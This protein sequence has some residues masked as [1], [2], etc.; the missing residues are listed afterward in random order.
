MTPPVFLAVDGGNSK[1]DVVI[2][3][4]DGRV[5]AAVRGPGS[6]PHALGLAGALDLLDGL[7]RRARDAADAAGPARVAR[8]ARAAVFLAGADL[9]VEVERLTAAV[10]GLGWADEST[11]DNDTFALLRAGTARPDAVA[12]VCGAGINCVGRAADGRM[13]RFLSLGTI[14]GDWGGGQHLAELA[15]WHAARGEDGRGPATAL[16]GAVALHFGCSTVEDVS[17]GLHLGGVPTDGVPALCEVLFDVAAAGD[18]VAGSV[19]SR[20]AEEVVTMARVAAGRLG[21]TGAPHAV[22]LGGGVLRA[23]HPALHGPVVAGIRAAAPRATVG[24]VTDPPVVGAALLALDDLVGRD[25]AA[26]ATL[27]AVEA[28]LRAAL[29]GRFPASCE[30]H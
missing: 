15:L 22:V 27:P 24:V 23:R 1:T 25:P 20:Q 16:S 12:V 26:G 5:L 28:M 7:V 18:P 10:A 13:A 29:R 9:P 6:S 19:V 21:L 11:V 30:C 8:P 2:G 3:T 17:A 4:A 14:S